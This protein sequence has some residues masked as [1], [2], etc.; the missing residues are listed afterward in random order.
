MFRNIT[1][2]YYFLIVILAM[3]LCQV[4]IVEFGGRAFKLS[5]LTGKEHLVCLMIGSL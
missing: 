1:N 4:L 3:V 2:L 5:P